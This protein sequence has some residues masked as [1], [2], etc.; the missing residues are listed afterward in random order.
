[1]VGDYV[2]LDGVRALARPPALAAEAAPDLPV[3]PLGQRIAVAEDD[4][5]AFTYAHVLAGWH[6]AGASL[7][8]FS[9]LA[10][11]A[12]DPD[13][14]AVYLPGG[15]PELW[16]G[17]L[18]EAGRFMTGLAKAAARGAVVY[19][20]CGGYMV[21]GQS[22]VD[23]EGRRHRMAGLLGLESSFAEPQRRLGYRQVR[24]LADGV[25]G[26]AGQGFRGH[27]FHYAAATVPRGAVPLLAA[28]D[29]LGRELG[30][31]GETRGGVAGS[32]IHLVDRAG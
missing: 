29:A 4:A 11:Q 30:D 14:D 28:A 13:A 12:P 10:N 7:T 15:Y 9:P 20:E 5:F 17:Q 27:E 31:A 2:D 26:P 25:L 3:P 24:L 32:F 8:R 21:L 6:A 19:G 1:V 16:A 23:A 22:L 18:A